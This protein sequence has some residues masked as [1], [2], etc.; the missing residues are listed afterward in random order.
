MWVSRGG[1]LAQAT[2]EDPII[3]SPFVEPAR[4]FVMDTD[5]KVTGKIEARRRPSEFYPPPL[6]R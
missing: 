4:H 3:N 2:I 1:N 5:G 6:C